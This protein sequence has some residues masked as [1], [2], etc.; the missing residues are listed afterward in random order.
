MTN[1]FEVSNFIRIISNNIS[2][3]YNKI[4]YALLKLENYTQTR[5][6]HLMIGDHFELVES[7]IV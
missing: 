2:V 5:G 7:D 1:F 3:I 4:I 6:R